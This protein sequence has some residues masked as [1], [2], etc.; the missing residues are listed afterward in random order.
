MRRHVSACSLALFIYGLPDLPDSNSLFH[1]NG[2]IQRPAW[3]WHE[4]QAQTFGVWTSMWA[5]GAHMLPLVF[6]FWWRLLLVQ[7]IL[8]SYRQLVQVPCCRRLHLYFSPC[9]QF[10]VLVL[11]FVLLFAHSNGACATTSDSTASQ[12]PISII[13]KHMYPYTT[14][15]MA[16]TFDDDE[17]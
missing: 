10:C 12:D 16:S 3:Y 9:T 6:S 8:V 5:I 11:S 1:P 14:D 7:F 2:C 17:C 4:L 15:D 13:I